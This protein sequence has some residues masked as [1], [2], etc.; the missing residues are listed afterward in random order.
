MNLMDLL[1]TAGGSESI[2]KLAGQFGLKKADA[3]K[4]IGALSPALLHGLQKQTEW[5]DARLGLERAIASGKHL[6]YLDDPDRVNDDETRL[7][8]N[9]ILGHLFGSKDVSRNVAARAAGDTGID[10]SLIKKALPIVAALAMGAM[11]RN[12]KADGDSARG[13]RALTGLLAGS[14]G[15]FGLDDVRTAAGKFF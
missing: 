6:R 10:A 11:G 15:K 13:L 2:G 14:D 1:E 5:A 12:A 7:D 4:L 3:S 8:G 9:K